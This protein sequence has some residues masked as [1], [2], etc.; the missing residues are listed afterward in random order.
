MKRAEFKLKPLTLALRK[1]GLLVFAVT[2]APGAAMA[3]VPTGGVV[4][5][6]TASIANVSPTQQRI[7]QGSDKAVINW[8]NFSIGAPNSV[9]FVQPSSSSIVLNRVVGGNP[10]SILGSLSANGQVF[11][12]NPN[13]VYFGP[14]AVVDVSGIVATTL[15]I[16]DSDFMAG[17]YIFSRDPSSPSG[18]AIINDGVIRATP[19][20]YVVLAGD[21]ARN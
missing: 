8:Q 5:Q 15:N 6:G 11:L 1:A 14:N 3:Q 19:G 20:G 12:V 7:T 4:T 21:Y 9:V 10:S 17:R 18:T 13:G 2:L 16:R